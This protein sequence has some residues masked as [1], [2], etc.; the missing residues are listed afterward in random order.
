MCKCQQGQKRRKRQQ[1]P[2]LR[3]DYVQGLPVETSGLPVDTSY[4]PSAGT[5]Q[6]QS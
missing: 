4:G 6:E 5:S 1:T 2:I 3:V